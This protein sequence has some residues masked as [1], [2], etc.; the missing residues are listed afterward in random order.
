[1]TASETAAQGNSQQA[2]IDAAKAGDALH[3]EVHL[4][5][6]R[7]LALVADVH[8]VAQVDDEL[9]PRLL[10]VLCDVGD[11][12]GRVVGRIATARRA[13]V[14][15]D[16]ELQILDRAPVVPDAGVA[17]AA[18]RARRRAVRARGAGGAGRPGAS[19]RA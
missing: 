5:L 12:G 4:R 6:G 3:E 19:C 8:V 9:D 15:G 7:A 17:R 14:A 2:L 10:Q 11:D 18:R 16:P 13:R 1:M